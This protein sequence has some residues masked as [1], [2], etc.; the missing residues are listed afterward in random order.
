[1]SSTA[2]ECCTTACPPTH[3][4]FCWHEIAT[5]DP[6]KA[7]AF[8]SALAGWKAIGCPNSAEYTEWEVGGN[9][10]G[11][12]RKVGEG[13]P[14]PPH[15][16]QYIATDDIAATCTAATANG[17][18]VLCGPNE[19]EG[20]GKFAC[21]KDA[22]GAVVML[23]QGGCGG[24]RQPCEG[25]FCWNELMVH[26]VD[27]A[28]KFWTK[29]IGWDFSDNHMGSA[30]TYTIFRLGGS[31]QHDKASGV[32]GCMKITPEMGPLPPHWLSYIWTNDIN[33]STAKV[34]AL[35]GKVVVP[36]MPIPG[37]GQFSVFQDT[38]GAHAALYQPAT[39]PKEC[40][41]G[42]GGCGG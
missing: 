19:M 5:T 31:D 27:A 34:T 39:Q 33:A 14:T 15:W 17:G 11:G 37:I 24:D 16:T 32:C 2:A 10:I 23:F 3:G 38:V 22:A 26:D 28:K 21:V 42:E 12:I 25:S 6:A 1:M 9:R 7:I 40:C 35:G 30:G 29:V 18:C 20:V 8:Y 13:D 36:V 4:T 41:C